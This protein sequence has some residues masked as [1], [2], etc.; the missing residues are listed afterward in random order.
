MN[1]SLL[2]V[3]IPIWQMGYFCGTL[4]T[5]T[6]LR[7]LRED[8]PGSSFPV[9]RS[10]STIESGVPCQTPVGP[11]STSVVGTSGRSRSRAQYLF[12]RSDPGRPEQFPVSGSVGLPLGPTSEGPG[13][14]I[15]EE[16]YPTGV[17]DKTNPFRTSV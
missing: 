14:G 8:R 13:R 2:K 11:N 4:S 15:G 3:P 10:R 7:L 17:E 16:V 9:P 1:S 12:L 5:P 6:R